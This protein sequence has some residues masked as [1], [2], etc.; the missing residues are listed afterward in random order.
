MIQRCL[1]KQWLKALNFYIDIVYTYNFQ[2]CIPVYFYYMKH[3]LIL[4][5]VVQYEI[6]FVFVALT[7]CIYYLSLCYASIVDSFKANSLVTK[8]LYS[9]KECIIV[10]KLSTS[11]YMLFKKHHNA[12]RDIT[13]LNKFELTFYYYYQR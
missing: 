5:Y 3:Y 10:N 1:L 4:I 9:K 12:Q 2:G 13:K 8:L 6:L 7:I 11:Y